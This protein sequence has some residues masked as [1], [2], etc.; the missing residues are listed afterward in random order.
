MNINKQYAIEALYSQR[1][2]HTVL[3]MAIKHELNKMFL[4]WAL[5]AFYRIE[6]WINDSYYESKNLRLKILKDEIDENGLEPIL[7]A[8]LASVL[9]TYKYQ[10]IQQCVGYLQAYLPHEDPFQRA[11]TAAELLALC[12]NSYNL[13]FIK[14]N[15]RGIPATV[16]VHHW[17]ELN[18]KLLDTFVWINNTCFNPP[19]V[20]PPKQVTHNQECGYLSLHEPLL[21]GS[22]TQHTEKQDYPAI[23][24]LNK[25]EWVL[26]QS[27]LAEPENPGK[28]FET[29]EQRQNFIDMV[30]ASNF[31]YN[32]L[33]EDPFYLCWQYDSRGRLYSH[34]YH[35][36]LQAAEYKKASLSFNKFEVLT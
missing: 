32:L 21:L 1:N 35:V 34:G 15:G 10:T 36:N 33:A 11:R 26:D 20:A 13:Y 23:N 24:L 14:S 31:I 7:I 18:T 30:A 3:H 5:K 28:P 8:I 2:K 6:N 4:H 29:M 19:M 22:L 16:E 27:V 9:H 12:S 25:V 17:E